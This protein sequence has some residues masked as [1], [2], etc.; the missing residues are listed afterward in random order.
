MPKANAGEPVT[1]TVQKSRSKM[2][3]LNLLV[4]FV[5]I[6]AA[7]ILLEIGARFLPPPF[8]DSTNAAEDCWQPA[9]W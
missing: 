7:L 1:G 3:L 5:G 2:V 6:V 4:A 9:G 8:E